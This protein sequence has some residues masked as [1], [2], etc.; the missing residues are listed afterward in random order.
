M[1]DNRGLDYSKA[2][3]ESQV[4]LRS[5]ERSQTKALLRDRMRFLRLLKSGACTSQAQA[6]TAIGLGLRGAE[7]LWRKYSH[8]G[9]DVLLRYPYQG[10]KEKLDAAQKQALRQE[11]AKD[12]TQSLQQVCQYVGKQSGVHYTIPGMHYVLE[13]MKVKKKTGRPVYH[14]KDYKGENQ[15]KKKS[16]RL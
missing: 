5:L 16:F 4:Q 6:G 12:Q 7:K 14:S 13:R 15:F 2:I 9:L 8:E 3:K 11:L 1:K 10:R